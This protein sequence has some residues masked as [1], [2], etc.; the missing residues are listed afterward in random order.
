MDAD[1]W[2]AWVQHLLVVRVYMCDQMQR[3]DVAEMGCVY[4]ATHMTAD[5]DVGGCYYFRSI[6]GTRGE[7]NVLQLIGFKMSTQWCTFIC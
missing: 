2:N 7:M 4:S 3:N 6:W 5:R 1:L